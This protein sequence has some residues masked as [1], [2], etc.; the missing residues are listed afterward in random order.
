MEALDKVEGFECH[1]YHFEIPKTM[2][3]EVCRCLEKLIHHLLCYN[4]YVYLLEPTGAIETFY[5]KNDTK[6]QD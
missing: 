4:A 3:I 6:D 2:N 1:F 5:N